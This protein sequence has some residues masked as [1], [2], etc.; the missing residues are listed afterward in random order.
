VP[1]GTDGGVTFLGLLASIAGSACIA[2]T[3]LVVNQIA[4]YAN[5]LGMAQ[6]LEA[7]QVLVVAFAA[8]LAG[9]LLDSCLGATLQYSGW[10]RGLKKVV[11]KPG[12]DVQHIVGRH[13]LTN[14]GVNASAAA[15]VSLAAALAA[16]HELL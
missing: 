6:T 15:L 4:R 9:S 11:G 8:G 14:D 7:R 12:S 10:H 1:P 5:V 2:T 3:W 13:V 16:W